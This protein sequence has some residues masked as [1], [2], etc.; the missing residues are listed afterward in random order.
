[1]DLN[2]VSPL[3]GLEIGAFSVEHVAFNAICFKQ[4]DQI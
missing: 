3:E 2:W 4:S 1:M